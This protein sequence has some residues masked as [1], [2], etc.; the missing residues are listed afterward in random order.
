MKITLKGTGPTGTF[1]AE[2]ALKDGIV[3]INEQVETTVVKA[4]AS[5]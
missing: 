5:P 3:R 1:T 2:V 4:C